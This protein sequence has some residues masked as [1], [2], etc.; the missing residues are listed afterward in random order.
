[1]LSGRHC[2]VRRSLPV[3]SRPFFTSRQ[4]LD[5]LPYLPRQISR[6]DH[7]LPFSLPAAGIVGFVAALPADEASD[8][9]ASPTAGSLAGL[10]W[11][12]YFVPVSSHYY[13]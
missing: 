7:D 9:H 12:V 11:S 5:A 3:T 13:Q 2:A 6:L 10:I 8:T 4:G 1:M